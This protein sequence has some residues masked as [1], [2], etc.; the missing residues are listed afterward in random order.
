MNPEQ[1]YWINPPQKFRLQNG[2]LKIQTEPETDFW[3]RTHYGFCKANAPAF[4]TKI[5]G[6]F[7]FGVKTRFQT[8]NRY[9]QCGVLLYT[10][11]KNWVKVSVEHEN[12]QF[13]R[14]GSVVTNLGYSDWATTDISFPVNEMSYRLSLEGQDAFIE[15]AEKDAGF[16]QMRI[17]H[18]HKPVQDAG[19]G[20]YAC[21]PMKSN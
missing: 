13:A 15:Y 19:I 21:S 14:L 6:D 20:V 8:Q 17:L 7:T 16:K 5:E 10:N 9:D 3:Q 1:F 18:L 11:E 4:L 2:V 12:K